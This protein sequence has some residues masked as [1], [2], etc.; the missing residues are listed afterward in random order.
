M[1]AHV[2]GTEVVIYDYYAVMVQGQPVKMCDCYLPEYGLRV[3]IMQS[4]I[5]I[6]R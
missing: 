5:Q 4:D 3:G 1:K 6:E 2:K